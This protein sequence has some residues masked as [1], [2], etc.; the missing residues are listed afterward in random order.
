MAILSAGPC[1]LSLPDPGKIRALR[2]SRKAPDPRDTPA[3]A[4][5]TARLFRALAECQDGFI[6]D[7]RRR[8]LQIGLCADF[9]VVDHFYLNVCCAH[10]RSKLRRP[11]KVVFGGATKL[12]RV[13][14]AEVRRAFIAHFESCNGY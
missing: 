2:L 11:R 1:A 6:G 4:Q 7:F 13:V 5:A 8:S 9:V 3:L 12:A 10:R 14:T